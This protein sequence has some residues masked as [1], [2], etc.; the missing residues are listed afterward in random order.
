MART[1]RLE[2]SFRGHA[3][4]IAST[5]EIEAC[6][7]VVVALVEEHGMHGVARAIHEERAHLANFRGDGEG[8]RAE[9]CRARDLVAEIGAPGHLERLERE[10]ASA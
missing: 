6:L 3:P 1:A 4:A 9:L 8:F 7:A 10:L 2:A 5:P